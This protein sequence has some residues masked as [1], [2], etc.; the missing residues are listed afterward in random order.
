M[1]Q[2]QK[3]QEEFLPASLHGKNISKML[4]HFVSINLKKQKIETD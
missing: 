3:E 1:I 4:K 2:A